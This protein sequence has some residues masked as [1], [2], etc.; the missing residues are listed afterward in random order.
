[1]KYDYLIVG[2]G[3]FGATFAQIA[4]EQGKKCLV[5]E[6]R[7]HIAGNAYTEDR[8][9]IAVHRYGAHIYI[10][11]EDERAQALTSVIKENTEPEEPILVMGNYCRLYLS[12]GNPPATY[13]P[14][15]SSIFSKDS[16]MAEIIRNKPQI[17]III[18]H[19][20]QHFM[21]EINADY[22]MIYEYESDA[23]NERTG[24]VYKRKDAAWLTPGFNK[25]KE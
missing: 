15:H 6:K 18:S 19:N 24:V 20:L 1:M 11:K 8:D 7:P 2:A 4:T 21:Q 16:Y 17:I 12:S 10:L 3:L 22:A 14:Y 23:D 25:V 13:Y 5:I 9:G